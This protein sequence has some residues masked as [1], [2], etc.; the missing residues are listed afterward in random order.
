M[1]DHLDTLQSQDNDK[2]NSY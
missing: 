1:V 2:E